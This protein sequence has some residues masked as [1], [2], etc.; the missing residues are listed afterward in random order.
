MQNMKTTETNKIY[1]STIV[2]DEGHYVGELTVDKI[3]S[4]LSD[5]IYWLFN[6]F[7]KHCAR[8]CA[9]P[10][11]TV[12]EVSENV[13]FDKNFADFIAKNCTSIIDF[14]WNEVRYEVSEI[15]S[16]IP[17]VHTKRIGSSIRKNLINSIDGHYGIKR[18]FER[19][20]CGCRKLQRA[21]L[22]SRSDDVK[23]LLEIIQDPARWYE[24]GAWMSSYDRW[25]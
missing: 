25:P 4:P 14:D 7:V 9:Y 3:D 21:K 6:R 13:F 24:L 12:S 2:E 11:Y 5:F 23:L 20:Q 1:F 19:L 16:A 8:Q 22:L 18:D 10:K 15:M 17:T